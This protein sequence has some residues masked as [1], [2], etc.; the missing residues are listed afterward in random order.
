MRIVPAILIA[1]VVG[2]TA[3]GAASARAPFVMMSPTGCVIG[4]KG[5]PASSIKSDAR[6]MTST[7]ELLRDKVAKSKV[8]VDGKDV[9]RGAA[10]SGSLGP[11]PFR[12][13]RG[14]ASKLDEMLD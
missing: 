7:T 1:A 8:A 2:V 14:V 9:V 13:E 5:C 11:R 4:E 3:S 12:Q 10:R 6:A